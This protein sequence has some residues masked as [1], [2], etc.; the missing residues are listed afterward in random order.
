MN[1]LA[2]LIIPSNPEDEQ[3]KAPPLQTESCDGGGVGRR[4]TA[5]GAGGGKGGGWYKPRDSAGDGERDDPL[6]HMHLKDLAI[7]VLSLCGSRNYLGVYSQ[8]RLCLTIDGPEKEGIADALTRMVVFAYTI[9]SFVPDEHVFE[10]MRFTFSYLSDTQ[11]NR[12][13]E[14]A[15]RDR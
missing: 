3:D 9:A 10:E 2:A 7:D 6:R 11:I 15:S 1:G 5:I 8:L 14:L 13:I 12:I 4:R